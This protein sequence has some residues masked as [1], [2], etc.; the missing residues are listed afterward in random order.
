MFSNIGR[1]IQ[2][3]A[4]VLC[5]MGIIL[6]VIAGIVIMAK[7]NNFLPQNTQYDTPLLSDFK[8]Q[9]QTGGSNVISILIG[10]AVIIFGSLISW[11]GSFAL[12]GFGT[13]I[14]DTSKL[15]KLKEE[16]A[17]GGYGCRK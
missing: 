15:R 13:L 10:L 6:C 2:I 9:N 17:E 8:N 7:G 16:E 14:D 11:L 3:L 12:Y 1:K 5:W 4:K